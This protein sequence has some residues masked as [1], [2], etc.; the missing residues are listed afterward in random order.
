MK[1]VTVR[2]RDE[3]YEELRSNAERIGKTVCQAARDRAVGN[4]ADIAW[5][6]AAETLSWQLGE[7]RSSL[8]VIIRREIV[9]GS[10]LY[11]EE[12]LEI[13]R[14]MAEV[15]MSVDRYIRDGIKEVMKRGNIWL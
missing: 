12:I 2:L 9:S 11:E 13:E 8:N 14:A 5:L 4:A 10:G 7:V 3:E 1:S 6:D 15:E